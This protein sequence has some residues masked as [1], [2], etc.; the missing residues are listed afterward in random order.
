MNVDNSL[1]IPGYYAEAGNIAIT[2]KGHGLK[3]AMFVCLFVF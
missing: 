1:K 3:G 2:R